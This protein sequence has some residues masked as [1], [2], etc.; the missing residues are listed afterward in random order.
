[1]LERETCSCRRA[2]THGTNPGYFTNITNF[3]RAKI[4]LIVWTE[5]VSSR[6]SEARRDPRLA[7]SQS[8]SSLFARFARYYRVFHSNLYCTRG[9]ASLIKLC[10]SPHYIGKHEQ[11]IRKTLFEVVSISG[12]LRTMRK[13]GTIKPQSSE[14]SWPT[15]AKPNRSTS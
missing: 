8:L 6:T 11:I 1:M 10:S 5:E 15:L 4:K 12:C 13:S 9:L 2:R 14:L 3:L 7:S